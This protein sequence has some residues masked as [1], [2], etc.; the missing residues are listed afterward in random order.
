MMAEN[1]DDIVAA[2]TEEGEVVVYSSSGLIAK[3]MDH[4]QAL[5]LGITLTLFD[6]GSVKTIEKQCGSK[7]PAFLMWT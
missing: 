7:R 6:L 5:Y 4:F 3:L 2:A 1:W